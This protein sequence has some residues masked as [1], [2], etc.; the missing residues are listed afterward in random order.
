MA[1]R[2]KQNQEKGGKVLSSSYPAEVLA[3]SRHLGALLN[4]ASSSAC[5]DVMW[6]HLAETMSWAQVSLLCKK[7]SAAWAEEAAAAA[8][9]AAREKVKWEDHRLQ[10]LQPGSAG[11][12]LFLPEHSCPPH[13]RKTNP[14]DLPPALLPPA[15]QAKELQRL[16]WL[17]VPK[18]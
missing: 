3:A 4:E 1:H 12:C 2:G 5:H 13:P 15:G 8:G 11:S 9:E 7:S 6:G 17:Q 16:W 10:M 18:S 14:C